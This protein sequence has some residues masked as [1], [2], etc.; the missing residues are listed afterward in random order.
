MASSKLN[1]HATPAPLHCHRL[2]GG[3]RA[4]RRN[5]GAL[6]AAGKVDGKN[7]TCTDKTEYNGESLTI[8]YKA[9]LETASKFSGSV[10]VEEMAIS[11]EFTAT[12]SKE[13]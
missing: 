12:L 7:V 5:R 13:P 10:T 8:T 3:S 6:K 9:L 4:R 2:R 11:G 1:L